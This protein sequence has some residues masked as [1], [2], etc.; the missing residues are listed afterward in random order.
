MTESTKRRNRVSQADFLAAYASATS[1]AN[2]AEALGMDVNS[3][4]VR[5]SLLRKKGLLSKM[6]SRGRKKAAVAGEVKDE[7]EN[8]ETNKTEG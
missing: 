7:Q 3:F 6:F 1:P 4:N 5:A 2:G 8:T